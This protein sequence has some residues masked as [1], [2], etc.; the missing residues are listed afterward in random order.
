M[1]TYDA[2]DIRNVL[3]VG[4]GGAGKTTLLE[5]MLFTSG[6][7]HAHGQGRGRQHRL[8]PRPRGGQRKGISVSLAMAPVEMGRRQDQR[9]RRA[10]VRGLRRRRPLGDPGRRRACSSWSRPSTASRSR[11][12]SAGSWRSRP[13]SPARSSSTSSTASAPSFERTL[14]ELVTAFGT[15][16]AP[17]R[18]ADRRGARVPRGRR[19]AVGQGRTATTAG[20]HGA[21]GE[22]PDDIAAKAD[23]FREKLMEAVAEADDDAAREVPRGRASSPTTQI[24]QRRAR[25]VRRGRGSRPVLVAAAATPIGV[26]RL[27][28]VHRRRVPVARSTAAR[29]PCTAKDGARAERSCDPDGPLT[30]LVFK[31]V[32]DPFVGHIKMFRVFSGQGPARLARCTT[33]R[34]NT[35]ERVGQL[36]ALRGKDHETVSRGAGRR[37][38]RG[39]EARAHHDRRHVL[40]EGR[41]GDAAGDRPARAAA[42]RSRSRRRPRATRTSSR[43]RSPRIREDDPTLR[44]ERSDET[45]ETVMYGM[46]EAHLDVMIE[47][48][49]RKFGVDVTHA[50]GARSP[51]SETLKGHGEGARAAT[52]SSRAAH[53]QYA[54][55]WIEARAAPP[56]RRVRVRRQDLRRRDPQPVHPVASR[57]ASSRR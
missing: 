33:R 13:A 28:D 11:P 38:R 46:G 23:P 1:K 20:R 17:L 29:S 45:H 12:R 44:V 32:S 34:R 3:L 18:A 15:Q 54:V 25:R 26:D 52:S 40:G 42:R 43:P 49:K 16:V 55:C 57:R 14:D 35:E 8:R 10:R 30:A 37:H 22:W 53:G 5:A 21:E 50:P 24:V 2:K 19:P 39:R 4:H 27:H 56:R 36:F 9:A 47:R 6:A 48:M 7:D 51:T 31:T 41:P